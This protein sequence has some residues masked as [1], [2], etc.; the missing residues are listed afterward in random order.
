M[1]ERLDMPFVGQ[2]AICQ[3]KG[4][5][6]RRLD[7]KALLA[8]AAPAGKDLRDLQPPALPGQGQWAVSILGIGATFNSVHGAAFYCRS[9]S[10]DDRAV[11]ADIQREDFPRTSALDLGL[12]AH[13]RAPQ[14]DIGDLAVRLDDAVFDDA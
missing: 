14:G 5:P 3:L 13:D 4:L 2:L 7:P 12:T 1:S 8:R 10:S 6:V 9:L 11:I